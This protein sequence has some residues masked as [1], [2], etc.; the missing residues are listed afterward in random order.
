MLF[1][2]FFF[3]ASGTCVATKEYDAEGPDELSLAPG[4]RIAI[5]GRLV[6]CLGWFTGRKESTGEVGLVKTS[7]VEVSTEVHR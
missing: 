6:S 1:S 5:V 2:P 3:P 7:L 4:D